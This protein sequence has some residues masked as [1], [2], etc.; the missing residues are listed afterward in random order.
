MGQEMILITKEGIERKV[1]TYV[2]FCIRCDD[3]L[4]YFADL[5][6]KIIRITKINK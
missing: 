4:K 6:N 5:E 3:I 1:E 2:G